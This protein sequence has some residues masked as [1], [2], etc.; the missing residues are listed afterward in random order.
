M[1]VLSM[2]PFP[3]RYA[4]PPPAPADLNSVLGKG[5]KD[6]DADGDDD[7]GAGDDGDDDGPEDGAHHGAQATTPNGK[8]SNSTSTGST[9]TGSSGSS[10]S[11][12]SRAG[13]VVGAGGGPISPAEKKKLQVSSPDDH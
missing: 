7:D 6:D 9:S 8:Y 12:S 2:A 4:K 10:S 11:S 13:A 1:Q 3:H 5:A